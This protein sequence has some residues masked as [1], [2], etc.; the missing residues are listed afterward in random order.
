MNAQTVIANLQIPSTIPFNVSENTQA[1]ADV[2]ANMK[3]LLS[4]KTRSTQT[5]SDMTRIHE[6]G[7]SYLCHSYA[8]ISC[9]R[10]LLIKL[11]KGQTGMDRLKLKIKNNSAQN[12]HSFSRMLTIF[13]GCINPRSFCGD[14]SKQAAMLET[15]V[16]RLVNKTAFEVEGWKRIIP[17]RTIFHELKLAIDD[18]ELVYKHVYHRNSDTIIKV[19]EHYFGRSWFSNTPE[20]FKV[21]TK[22]PSLIK[23]YLT[24]QFFLYMIII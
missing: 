1:S 9:L 4:T 17:V 15:V 14:T 6:Q 21:N 7:Y 13:L 5:S 11:V 20:R 23:K 8:A 3:D 24:S 19:L 12:D 18:Y 22:K 2:L 16:S 10:Q